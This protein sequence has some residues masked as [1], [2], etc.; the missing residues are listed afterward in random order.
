MRVMATFLTPEEVG[1]AG[2]HD[3]YVID[4]LNDERWLV[5]KK[6][7]LRAAIPFLVE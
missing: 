7:S 4:L 6:V 3:Y 1:K 5:V 2:L